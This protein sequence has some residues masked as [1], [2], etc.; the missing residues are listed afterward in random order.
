M[1]TVPSCSLAVSNNIFVKE[2]HELFKKERNVKGLNMKNKSLIN[3]N[4][5]MTAT[6]TAPLIMEG[7]ANHQHSIGRTREYIVT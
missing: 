5:L 4:L 6:R 1:S 3:A 2:A 7:E